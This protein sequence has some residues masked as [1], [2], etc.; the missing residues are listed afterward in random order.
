MDRALELAEQSHEEMW[1]EIVRSMENL[2]AE[3]VRTLE[4]VEKKNAALQHAKEFT[5]KIV[6]NMNNPLVVAETDGR[7][8]LANQACFA[9]LG[10]QQDELVGQAFEHLIAADSAQRFCPGAPLWQSILAG[11][12]VK[13]VELLF[14]AR[15]GT[16]LPVSFSAAALLDDLGD[17]AGIVCIAVDLR[18]IKRLL[19]AERHK[20]Q[21]LEKA[22][23]DL[24]ELQNRLVHSEKMSSLGRM[25]AG[26][27]HEINSPL[28]GVMVY[29]H[30]LLEDTPQDD[31]RR[32]NLLKIVQETERCQKIVRDM[33]EFARIHPGQKQAADLNDLIRATLAA[34]KDQPLFRQIQVELEL[35]PDLPWSA[36]E[37]GQLQQAFSNIV[38][39]AAQAMNGRGRLSVCSSV[40]P[41]SNTVLLSFA[42]D[43]CGV[44]PENL[45]RLFEPFFTTK[46][47]QGGTGL[48]LAITHSIIERHGGKL[49]VRSKVG[50]GTTVLV[51]IPLS[52]SGR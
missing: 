38:L 21:A 32:A 14:R 2:Y 6:S 1:I 27:V 13:D 11:E 4:E 30:L 34:L 10:Y 18:E 20:S 29:S 17:I 49:E 31:A 46:Q 9:L 25:A 50:A 8:R 12:S 33:L 48:G 42:D 22:N 51:A 28:N 37:R 39:N 26:V 35:A 36:C 47:A 24:R 40:P 15:D 3:L 52:A 43:G 5:E 41:G 19:N 16:V 23:S 45:N 7:I 44:P